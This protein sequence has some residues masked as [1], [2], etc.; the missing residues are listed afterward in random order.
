[1]KIQPSTILTVISV[2]L[3]GFLVF[4]NLKDAKNSQVLQ[5]Q[6][7]SL[8]KKICIYEVQQEI[9]ERK[10]D[11]L[12]KINDSLKFRNPITIYN[13]TKY[14]YGKEIK[15]LDSSGI[16]NYLDILSK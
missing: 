5:I 1:M 13:E 10:N 8:N 11:S 12:T 7:D 4:F 15:L 2:I 3:L 16:N 14:K 9:L 6:L